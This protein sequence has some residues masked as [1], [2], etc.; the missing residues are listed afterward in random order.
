MTE[1]NPKQKL[2][3]KLFDADVEQA[4]IRSGFGDGL[5]MAGE[6]DPQVVALC[7]DLTE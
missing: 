3:D 2:N 5:L 7:A 6:A 1:L 4:P